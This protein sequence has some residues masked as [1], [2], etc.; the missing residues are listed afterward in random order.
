MLSHFDQRQTHE[1]NADMMPPWKHLNTMLRKDHAD[2][3]MKIKIYLMIFS[4]AILLC[5]ALT[6][7]SD[8]QW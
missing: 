3:P 2:A 6:E 4:L 5:P 1:R 8:H 7:Q